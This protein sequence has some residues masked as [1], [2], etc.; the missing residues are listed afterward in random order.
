MR[1]IE[2]QKKKEKNLHFLHQLK[3]SNTREHPASNQPPTPPLPTTL[4]QT[5][6]E[7]PGRRRRS[8][9]KVSEKT[10]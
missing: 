10:E 3:Q 4:H 8:P 7:E 6:P 9:T 1:K 5:P 2:E